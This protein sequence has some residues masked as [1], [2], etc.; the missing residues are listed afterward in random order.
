MKSVRLSYMLA[1]LLA[2]VM[3]VG[4]LGAIPAPER[5]TVP[6]VHL[7]ASDFVEGELVVMFEDGV[8]LRQSQSQASA[9]AGV[10]DAQVVDV[11]Q[12][13]ALLR[14]TAD[15]DLQAVAEIISAQSGVKTVAKNNIF[16]I[17]TNVQAQQIV[18]RFRLMESDRAENVEP[19]AIPIAQLQNAKQVTKG[20]ITSIYPND[21]N[22]WWNGGWAHVGADIVSPNRTVSKNVCVIDTGVD[23]THPDLIRRVGTTNV[24]SV[25]RGRDFVNN[26]ADPMDD[27]GHGTHVAG[28]IVATQGNARGIAGVAFNAKVVAV[29]A[30]SAQGT[31]TSWD[32]AQAIDFCAKRK[33]ISIINMSLGGGYSPLIEAAVAKATADDDPLTLPI[34][35]YSKVIV[36]SAGN[37]G[38]WSYCWND[39]GTTED[40]ADDYMDGDVRAYPAGF[41]TAANNYATDGTCDDLGTELHPA[42]PRVVSVAATGDYVDMGDWGYIDYYLPAPYSNYGDWVTVALPGTDI[43]STLP[44]DKP[45]N[46]QWNSGG[47]IEPRYGWLSGTSMAAPFASAILARTWGYYPLSPNTPAATKP[48]VDD[49]LQWFYGSWNEGI[50][51]GEDDAGE[52]DDDGYAI[53]IKDVHLGWAMERAVVYGRMRDVNT[54][55]SVK[56]STLAVFDVSTGTRL[57]IGAIDM[58]TYYSDDKPNRYSIPG[59]VAHVINVPATGYPTLIEPRGMMPGYTATATNAFVKSHPWNGGELYPSGVGELWPA[60]WL[61]VGTMVAPPR[62]PN[63]PSPV[64]GHGAMTSTKLSSCQT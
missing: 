27:N 31:G 58:L 24:P 15:A 9:L 54:N 41:A 46:M 14:F 10:I 47:W 61:D 18:P 3:I 52:A 50:G 28:V 2:V 55:M 6:E 51:F 16:R 48:P 53:T 26:D 62:S 19:L 12:G 63:L 39:N 23:Y 22:L 49:V 8:T 33:D 17:P 40:Y 42:Y 45:F 29:K 21:T 4:T 25:L 5:A 57:G 36:A 20:K 7:Q 30:L 56:G 11:V 32:V 64:A 35:G 60:Q 34:E 59:A 43:Y 38:V 1:I 13:A 37:D 44:W